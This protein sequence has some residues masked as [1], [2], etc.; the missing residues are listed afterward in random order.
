MKLQDRDYNIIL[1]EEEKKAY[2]A[3]LAYVA[4]KWPK[5]TRGFPRHSHPDKEIREF[6]WHKRSLFSNNYLHFS[7]Y[8]NELDFEAEADKFKDIIYNCKNELEIQQYIKQNKKWFI[9]G[10]IFVDYNFGHHDAYLFPEQELGN[11]FAVDY[12]LIGKNPD[13]YSIVLIE[14]EKTNT[15]YL[16]QT[17]NTESESL[18]KGLTQIQDW[19][20][21]MDKNRDYFLRNIGLLQ[22]GIGILVYQIHYYLV[23]SQRDFMT[24]VSLEVRSQSIYEM[25]K[26]RIVTFD[27]LVD[28]V[29]KLVK[30]HSL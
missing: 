13:G 30:N 5:S 26:I 23:V 11:E 7:E 3:E 24:P 12:M 22:H 15:E 10:S 19:K 8:K 17:R 29:R 21:W 27:R 16:L 2:E 4:I 14:F 9:P 28:N 18:R 25:K 6:I 20:R 1:N